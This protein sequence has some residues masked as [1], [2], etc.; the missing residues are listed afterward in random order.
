MPERHVFDHEVQYEKCGHQNRAD[1]KDPL[2]SAHESGSDSH[3]ERFEDMWPIFVVAESGFQRRA[4]LR[5][6]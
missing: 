2:Y 6:Q 5:E 3:V 4:H 1:Q